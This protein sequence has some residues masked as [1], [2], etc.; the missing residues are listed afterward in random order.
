MLPRYSINV[1]PVLDSTCL[2][3][4]L[5]SQSIALGALRFALSFGDLRTLL[6]LSGQN[7][8][9]LEEDG[10]LN[11]QRQATPP[12]D[13]SSLIIQSTSS[14]WRLIHPSLR[15]A[16]C[17][18]LKA[19]FLAY[20]MESCL[21]G[22]KALSLSCRC[23]TLT[24]TVQRC[25]LYSRTW[26]F[27]L[28]RSVGSTLS[29][30]CHSILPRSLHEYTSRVCRTHASHEER[31]LNSPE[32]RHGST[33]RKITGQHNHASG[34][35]SGYEASWTSRRMITGSKKAVSTFSSYSQHSTTP[36][37]VA[38]EFRSRTKP[39]SLLHEV[40]RAGI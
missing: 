22:G 33:S 23:S 27:H 19:K 34:K 21:L 13:A 15:N 31:N 8:L 39:E 32:H 4:S 26:C 9:A 30:L 2:A 11:L 6:V 16:A 12:A 17:C 5:S 18:A 20:A 29:A 25:Y 36:Y 7:V 24:S 3:S 10:L 38:D 14:S 28:L 37:V 40:L 1:V 35:V